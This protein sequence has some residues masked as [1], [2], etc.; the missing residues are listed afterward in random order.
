MASGLD[1]LVDD[2]VAYVTPWG[3][4]LSHIAAPVLLVH[5][6][7]DLVGPA[8]HSTWLAAHIA[9]AELWL[10]EG[11]SHISALAAE[12]RGADD[13]LRWLAAHVQR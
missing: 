7:D 2:D 10:A 6:A 4:E 5:G 8:S 13:A 11:E 3:V 12:H 9:N 1:S